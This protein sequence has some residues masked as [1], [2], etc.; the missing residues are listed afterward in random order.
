MYFV[1]SATI[2]AQDFEIALLENGTDIIYNITFCLNVFEKLFRYNVSAT[3][4]FNY[5]YFYL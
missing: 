5:L 2:N 3:L 1:I 4:N